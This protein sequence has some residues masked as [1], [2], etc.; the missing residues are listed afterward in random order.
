MITPAGVLLTASY[1][2]GEVVKRQDVRTL[3]AITTGYPAS[4]VKQVVASLNRRCVA[5]RKSVSERSDASLAPCE[6]GASPSEA[7][8]YDSAAC[9]A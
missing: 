9:A 2:K 8:R 3:V 7:E 4:H 5:T 6:A 1:R